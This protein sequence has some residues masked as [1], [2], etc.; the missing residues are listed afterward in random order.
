MKF[1]NDLVA[2]SEYCHFR[3]EELELKLMMAVEQ[4]SRGAVESRKMRPLR[5]ESSGMQ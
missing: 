2:Y 5:E 1:D 3:T 4:K